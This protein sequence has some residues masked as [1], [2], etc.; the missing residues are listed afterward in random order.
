M[1]RSDAAR[2]LP[3]WP[4]VVHHGA[5]RSFA[6]A[7]LPE[8]DGCVFR[9]SDWMLWKASGRPHV[10]QRGWLRSVRT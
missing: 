3:H 6:T 9:Q 1:L 2:M 10:H 7:Y 8:G 5:L 4:Y